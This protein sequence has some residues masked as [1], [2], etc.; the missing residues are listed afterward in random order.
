MIWFTSDTHFSH[1][2]IILYTSR[3]FKDVYEMNDA[4]I[5][6]INAVVKE[7]DTLWHLGDVSLNPAA[8]K[9]NIPRINCKNLLLIAGNHDRVWSMKEK[10]IN[11]YKEWGFTEIHKEPVIGYFNDVFFTLAHHYDRERIP[12]PGFLLHGH[13]HQPPE[14]AYNKEDQRLDVGV[15][16]HS[17]SPWSLDEI[18]ELIK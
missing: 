10:W 12:R 2:N 1:A 5:A 3:P 15:D 17:Y 13:S 7:D 18:L 11:L 6:N 16:G 4:L 9:H 8:V 14:K